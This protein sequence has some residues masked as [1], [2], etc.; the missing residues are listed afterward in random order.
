MNVRARII[1][2]EFEVRKM[3]KIASAVLLMCERYAPSETAAFAIL[4]NWSANGM[5]FHKQ[6]WLK[7]QRREESCAHPSFLAIM[8]SWKEKSSSPSSCSYF[9]LLFETGMIIAVLSSC[10]IHRVLRGQLHLAHCVVIFL[11]SAFLCLPCAWC[12]VAKSLN[13]PKQE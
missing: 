12:R 1:P 8:M 5:E 6:L 2:W 10:R 11:P 7:Q 3:R 9:P 13:N 4:R